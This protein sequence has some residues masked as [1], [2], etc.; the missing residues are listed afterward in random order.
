MISG[1]FEVHLIVQPCDQAQLFSFSLDK[2]NDQQC[3]NPRPTC[4]QTFYGKYPNQPML[5]F[6][7]RGTEFEAIEYAQKTQT[8]MTQEGMDVLRLKVEAM[9]HNEGVPTTAEETKNRYF[10]FHFK[11]PIANSKEWERLKLICLK[12]GAHLFFNPYSQ[13]GR[14]QPVV[15]LRR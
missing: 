12:H 13:T 8:E 4:A 1:V 2:K 7:F 6:W 10:E 14:M 9:A 11:V 3:I 15:T 5:T